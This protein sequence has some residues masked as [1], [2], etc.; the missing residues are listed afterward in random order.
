MTIDFTDN[1]NF[2]DT[3]IT[4]GNQLKVT[5]SK[6]QDKTIY[7]ASV[8]LGKNTL[9]VSNT[10]DSKMPAEKITKHMTEVLNK[11]HDF[12]KTEGKSESGS[13]IDNFASFTKKSNIYTKQQGSDNRVRPEIAKV[14]S[15][16]EA[17]NPKSNEALNSQSL[18][19]KVLSKVLDVISNLFNFG[20]KNT[21]STLDVT[22][23]N[24]MERLDTIIQKKNYGFEDIKELKTLSQTLR[25]LDEN[26]DE[27]VDENP[28]ESTALIQKTDSEKNETLLNQTIG[29]IDKFVDTLQDKL[30]DDIK[31]AKPKA[32]LA[33]M[34]HRLAKDPTLSSPEAVLAKIIDDTSPTVLKVY[35]ATL[36]LHEIEQRAASAPLDTK[37]LSELEDIMQ[38]CNELRSMDAGKTAKDVEIRAMGLKYQNRAQKLLEN[39]NQ[40]EVIFFAGRLVEGM[41]KMPNSEKVVAFIESFKKISEKETLSESDIEELKTYSEALYMLSEQIPDSEVIQRDFHPDLA[42]PDNDLLKS[43]DPIQRQTEKNKIP[44]D[45]SIKPTDVKL[46]RAAEH[47]MKR[48]DQLIAQQEGVSRNPN[49][50]Y[51]FE[52]QVEYREIKSMEAPRTVKDAATT[53]VPVKDETRGEPAKVYAKHL[54]FSGIENMAHLSEQQL[55]NAFS[56][57]FREKIE[58]RKAEEQNKTGGVKFKYSDVYR[59]FVEGTFDQ[60][61]AEI[62]SGVE[63]GK[64][65]KEEAFE[66]FSQNVLTRLKTTN[67]VSEMIDRDTFIDLVGNTEEK[68]EKMPISPLGSNVRNLKKEIFTDGTWGADEERNFFYQILTDEE[69]IVFEQELKNSIQAS[70]TAVSHFFSQLEVDNNRKET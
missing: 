20:S 19:S 46:A 21:I 2:K 32:L 57:D 18:L 33:D 29:S 62:S 39:P 60:S 14:R 15:L 42:A 8:T 23:N 17:L 22:V 34:G 61:L 47:F 69:L 6:D 13:F 40:V 11:V 51:N 55:Q 59:R 58:T 36:K 64:I 67:K 35:T 63:R 12:I 7:T 65:S 50:K 28:D 27:S 68:R 3:G 9:Y 31:T 54:G 43:Q 24:A 30:L 5:T 10:Y 26:V 52:E 49:P 53:R 48:C 37:D 45:E 41:D 25:S 44:N 16:N 38:A 66:E 70:E 56:R 4:V 1:S